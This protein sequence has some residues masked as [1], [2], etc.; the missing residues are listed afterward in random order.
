MIDKIKQSKNQVLQ[1]MEKSL[2]E[3]GMERMDVQ[4]IGA[5]AD[6]VKDLSEAEKACLEAEYYMAVTNAMEQGSM[7]YDGMGY[8]NMG[9]GSRGYRG[10]NRGYRGNSGYENMGYRNSRRGHTDVIQN[11]Q[12]MLSTASPQEREQMKMQLR[13]MAE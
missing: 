5:L 6:I 3:R 11:M 7:G 12:D 10:N 2:T 4:E 9:Y 8:D 1:R 13:Q